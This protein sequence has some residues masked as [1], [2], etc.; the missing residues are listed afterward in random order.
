[1]SP[2]SIEFKLLTSNISNVQEHQKN[3]SFNKYYIA[4]TQHK[5]K[6]FHKPHKNATI[7]NQNKNLTLRKL[8]K[9]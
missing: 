9:L 8:T 3:A 7:T 6:P 1:M 4:D 5:K 2:L